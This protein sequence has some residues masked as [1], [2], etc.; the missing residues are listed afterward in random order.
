MIEWD[1]PTYFLFGIAMAFAFVCLRQ[2]D[3]LK[4]RENIA[5]LLV[6][7]LPCFCLLAFRHPDVGKDLYTYAIGVFNAKYDAEYYFFSNGSL[8]MEPLSKLIM[9]LSYRLGGLQPF[10]FLTSLAQY[11]LLVLFLKKIRSLGF[12]TSIVFLLFFSVIMLRSCSMVRN[13]MALSASFC[14]YSYLLGDSKKMKFYW[15]FTAIAIGF[16]NSAIINVPIYFLC[17]PIRG[18]RWE[19]Y[20]N[21]FLKG[22]ALLSVAVCFYLLK[23]GL[24]NFW[25]D[26]LNDGKYAGYQMSNSWGIGNTIIRLPL[27]VLFGLYLKDLKIK[28]GTKIVSCYYLLLFDLILS[29][30]RYLYTDFERLTQYPTFG[31]MVLIAV[32]Y[33]FIKERVRFPFQLVYFFVVTLYFT[34]YMYRW[35][36]IDEYGLMPYK[37]MGIQ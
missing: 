7:L 6:G 24:L 37:F 28:Y 10:I 21:I 32:F 17:Q 34:Y 14:A 3:L 26:S 15:L 22:L 13:G 8:V 30:S 1:W 23:T 33:D 35:A 19:I 20:R 2:Y 18:E 11:I 12:N 27:I 36:I 25:I 16:H 31:E 29:Q 9:F 5:Y 4:T